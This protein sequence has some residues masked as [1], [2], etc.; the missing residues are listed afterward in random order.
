[1]TIEEIKDT[2]PA[3]AFLALRHMGLPFVFTWE[4][5]YTYVSAA[6]VMT[7]RT[8]GGR[9]TLR[10]ADHQVREFADPFAAISAVLKEPGRTQAAS[11]PFASGFAGYFGYGLRD[12]IEPL[13][14][15]PQRGPAPPWPECPDCIVGLYDPVFVY[16]REEGRG[17]L[18]S[19][20]GERGRM[21]AFRTALAG[22]P[23]APGCAPPGFGGFTPNI[24][25]EEYLRAIARAKEY[26]S[27]GDIY[28]INISQRLEIPFEGD[29]F[30]LYLGLLRARPAPFSSFLDCGGFQVI[31]NSPE[32]L[33]RVE[34]G[35][36][37]TSPIKGTRPRGSTPEKD[38]RLIEELRDSPKERAEHVMIVDL[39]RNDLGRISEP[40]SV[41]VPQFE[42]IE[43][44]PTL[45][46]MVSTVRGRLRDGVDA[47][48]A[49]RAVFPGGSITGAPKI[50]A[51]EIIDELEAAPRGI[52]TGGIGWI[53][54]AGGMDVSMA[55]RT[56]VCRDGSLS[57]NVGGG[58][59]ADSVAEEEYEETLLKARDFLDVMGE[60][61]AG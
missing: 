23:C 17:W 44:Y 40:G 48:T 5:R 46:H 41:E 30:A 24:T 6:P 2:L 21:E 32:R 12:V 8:E 39:E 9:T 43:S 16:D 35:V 50:R 37:E 58:I 22:A 49:L 4:G 33:L 10:D 3:G 27:A 56:S 26:I 15:A 31:S 47:P 53:D 61:A 52:Y 38:R 29:P 20:S 42:A 54:L 13:A 1:M 55:I 59:V 36:A 45:H 19:S 18:A 11:F 60:A 28:Q 51:M 57:L 7:V 34:G 25:K 14:R